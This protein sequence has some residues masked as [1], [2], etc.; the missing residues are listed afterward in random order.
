[1]PSAGT[2]VG[3]RGDGHGGEQRVR[4]TA[5]LALTHREGTRGDRRAALDG[6]SP[7][8]SRALARKPA[9]W[10]FERKKSSKVR[11]RARAQAGG[12]EGAVAQTVR[13]TRAEDMPKKPGRK[14]LDASRRREILVPTLETLRPRRKITKK[15]VDHEK[16]ARQVNAGRTG[17]MM[18]SS[19]EQR[20]ENIKVNF[21]SQEPPTAHKQRNSSQLPCSVDKIR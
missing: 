19:P 15:R 5:A 10:R 20:E 16:R 7:P 3:Q 12:G 9:I 17:W 18:M 2:L 4:I 1:M 13:T 11:G 8:R 21:W 14:V 6:S